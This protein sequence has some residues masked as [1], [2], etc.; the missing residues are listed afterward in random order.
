MYKKAIGY[1]MAEDID[2]KAVCIEVAKSNPSVFVKAFEKI[3]GKIDEIVMYAH[4][5]LYLPMDKFVPMFEKWG[6]EEWFEGVM[7]FLF[8]NENGGQEKIKAIK[9]HRG[10]TNFGL[11]ESKEF[12]ESIIDMAGVEPISAYDAD[13][14]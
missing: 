12:V 8:S 10:A 3:D 9:I 4:K 5:G 6:R 1:L 2:F 13:R 7:S 14:R 11:R